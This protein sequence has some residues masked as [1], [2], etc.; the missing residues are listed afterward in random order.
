M[1]PA[2]ADNQTNRKKGVFRMYIEQLETKDRILISD[3][4]STLFDRVQRARRLLTSSLET[5]TSALH[6]RENHG[7]L[8]YEAEQFTETLSIVEDAL[9]NICLEYGLMIGA[10]D[11]DGVLT[12]KDCMGLIIGINKGADADRPV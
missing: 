7:L 8:T 6:N 1:L 2:T 4:T 9:F 11:Y 10:D 3:K 5:F 12:L